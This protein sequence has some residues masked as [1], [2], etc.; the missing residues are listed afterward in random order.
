MNKCVSILGILLAVCLLSS[1]TGKTEGVSIDYGKSEVYSTEDMNA[2]IVGI[3]REFVTFQGC[4]LH[5]L[6]YAGDDICKD[7]IEYCRSL[8]E[9][10]DF[11]E[12]IVFNS[13]F[14]SP[15]N[16][17]GAWE[18]D[19]EYTWTWYL[20]RKCNGDWKLLGYGYG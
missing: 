16:G 18:A 5:S 1:C 2:A 3:K 17:G 15:Q 20:A 6:S 13:S 10:M 9:S 19:E 12:C 7:S 4:V 11:V 8:D 14:H